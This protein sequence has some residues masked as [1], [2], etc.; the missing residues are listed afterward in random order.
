M[1]ITDKDHSDGNGGPVTIEGLVY[2]E[3]EVHIHQSDP[4]NAVAM[5]GIQIADKVHNCEWFWFNYAPCSGLGG[6]GGS[7]GEVEPLSWHEVPYSN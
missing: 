5:E 4:Y 6:F 2:S 7:G 1:D 3:G